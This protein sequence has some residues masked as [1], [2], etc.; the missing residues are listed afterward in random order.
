MCAKEPE[1]EDTP[2]VCVPRCVLNRAKQ[3]HS[4]FH[5][6]KGTEHGPCDEVAILAVVEVVRIFI[7]REDSMVGRTEEDLV[8]PATTFVEIET[9][10]GFEVREGLGSNLETESGSE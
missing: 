5:V 3:T 1:H 2:N 8:A 10:S 6:R 7:G 9:T 4:R